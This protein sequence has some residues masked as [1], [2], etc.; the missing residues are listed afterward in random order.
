MAE[1]LPTIHPSFISLTR[2]ISGDE[3]KIHQYTL[4]ICDLYRLL[5]GGIV[6]AFQSRRWGIKNFCT[7]PFGLLRL[8]LSL[9]PDAAAQKPALTVKSTIGNIYD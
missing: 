8:R 7:A 1:Q 3:Q 4:I 5:M 9:H 2:K 6:Y